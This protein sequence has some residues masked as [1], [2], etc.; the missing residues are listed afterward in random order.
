MAYRH[1]VFIYDHMY[2]HQYGVLHL[3]IILFDNNRITFL[4][5]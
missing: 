1:H 5:C 4:G 2:Y 3:V